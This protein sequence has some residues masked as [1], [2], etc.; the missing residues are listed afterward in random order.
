MLDLLCFN[1][2]GVD[3]YKDQT[4]AGGCS[5]NVVRHLSSLT[6]SRP[7]NFG[8]LGPVGNDPEKII[9]ENSIETMN[10]RQH[11]IETRERT[12]KCHIDINKEGERSFSKYESPALENFV[13]NKEY[14]EIFNKYQNLAT[15]VYEQA[16]SSFRS[17]MELQLSQRVFCDFTD[18]KDFNSSSDIVREFISRVDI[19]FCGLNIKE[20]V[21]IN[22]LGKLS[23]EF[24]KLIVV[25]LGSGGSIAFDKGRMISGP[26]KKVKTIIDST[27]AGDSYMAAFLYS[28]LQEAETEFCLK[29]ATNYA[30]RTVGYLGAFR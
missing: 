30:A 27:G 17:F 11:L 5:L 7:A 6:E 25:T 13:F 14:L 1:D 22:D 4:F 19:V 18:L 24:Q 2:V 9:I 20:Q 15:V 23:K 12:T 28:Y 29:F 26:S 21:L 3:V 8:V 16:E 10:I